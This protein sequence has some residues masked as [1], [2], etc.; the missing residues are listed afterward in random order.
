MHVQKR[1][2]INIYISESSNNLQNGSIF[3]FFKRNCEIFNKIWGQQK[4]FYLGKMTDYY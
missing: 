3:F 4:Y 2:S 1:V